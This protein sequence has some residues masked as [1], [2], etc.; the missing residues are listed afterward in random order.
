MK[1][2][3]FRLV[4]LQIAVLFHGAV[5]LPRAPHFPLFAVGHLRGLQNVLYVPRLR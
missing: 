4:H 2:T 3:P 5:D 1:L